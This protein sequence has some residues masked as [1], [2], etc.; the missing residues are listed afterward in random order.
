ML[1][2]KTVRALAGKDM[3]SHMGDVLPSSSAK[4]SR[5]LREMKLTPRAT[6][7]NLCISPIGSGSTPSVLACSEYSSKFSA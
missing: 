3:G 4:R 6:G 1:V 2:V 7:A 5:I